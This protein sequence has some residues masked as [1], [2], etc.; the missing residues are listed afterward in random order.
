MKTLKDF[1]EVYKPK[2]PD[3]QKFVDKHVTIKFKDRNEVGGKEN[4][5]DV[6]NASNIK[7]VKRKDNRQGYD[8]G[9]DEKVYEETDIEESLGMGYKP[10]SEKSKFDD[11][12]RAKLL[13]P[14]GKVSYLSQKSYA[15]PKHAKDA[16]KYYHSIGHLPS[17]TIDNKMSQYNKNYDAKKESVEADEINDLLDEALAILE[18]TLTPAELKKREEIAKAIGR[19][20]PKMPMAQKMAIATA[21]AKKVAEEVEELDERDKENKF[22]KDLFVA[23]KGK[24]AIDRSTLGDHNYRA[25]DRANSAGNDYPL[26]SEGGIHARRKERV[27][28]YKSVGRKVMAKEEVEEIDESAKIVAH[29]QKRYGDNIRKSHVMSA[30]KDF[31]VDASKLAKAVRTK[32]GK[33]ML[34]EENDD[35]WYTHKEMYGKIPRDK[36]KQG[37]RYNN[38]KDKPFYHQPTKT[39][40]A[41]VKD[42][43]EEIDLHE[44][45]W[46]QLGQR[47]PV[48]NTLPTPKRGSV[49]KH[50]RRFSEG[51]YVVP[52]T[53]PH[54]GEVHKV[55]SSRVGSVNIVNPYGHKYD[56]ITVRAK[57]EHLSPA[58]K[59]QT[60]DHK[61]RFAATAERMKASLKEE[62]EAIDELSATTMQRYKGAAE[63][64]KD[65]ETG[66]VDPKARVRREKG[67]AMAT[68]K[69]AKE[70]VQIDELSKN[71]MLKYLSANKKSDKAAQE[72]GDYS[73]S[74]KRMRGTDVAVRKYTASPNSKYVRVPATEE[75]EHID[76]LSK[77]TLGS[78]LKKAA[79]QSFHKGV[80]GGLAIA[81]GI[82]NRDPEV[83]AQGVKIV[84]KA[85]KR[86]IGVQKAADRLTKEDILNR[87]IDK[88]VPEELKFTAEERLLKRLEGIQEG[89]IDKLM[90]LFESLN[91]SNQSKM[92]DSAETEEGLNQLLD[93]AINNRGA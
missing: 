89:H 28:D 73:K 23:K 77:K 43:K 3:E 85:A 87:A 52:H 80:S 70:D 56:S 66:T 65:Y 61:A 84:N 5:D 51:D 33:N 82:R 11:G 76:E 44:N 90:D 24:E 62:V 57:H 38:L 81:N 40:H 92:I 88:Y 74:D 59:Q 12:H 4:G 1:M 32:L 53:G 7:P 20:N 17:Q 29:L 48:G 25:V 79:N 19:G 14:D 75:V 41:S 31:G 21:Q 36:W 42:I 26:D 15:T 71:A 9:E 13:N 46:N 35:G 8:V 93:F 30:A 27:R 78:Y 45:A 83:E 6:F 10:T 91:D 49:E 47:K 58:T 72:K 67:I 54:A 86:M 55:T 18:K 63:W 68:K 16:A 37:W 69:I 39:W 50:G 22:K 64:D 2:A 60:D 34:P